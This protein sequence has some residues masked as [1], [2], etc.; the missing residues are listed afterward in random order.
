[1]SSEQLFNWKH[2]R[3]KSTFFQKTWQIYD[4]KN[5]PISAANTSHTSLSGCSLLDISLFSTVGNESHV[6][7]VKSKC[8]KFLKAWNQKSGNVLNGS[9]IY[10]NSVILQEIFS[11]RDVIASVNIEWYQLWAERCKK[12]LCLTS[13]TETE[14][15]LIYFSYREVLIYS[16]EFCKNVAGSEINW[17]KHQNGEICPVLFWDFCCSHQASALTLLDLKPTT[18]PTFI[19]PYHL[20]KFLREKP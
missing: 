15:G 14:I 7:N 3:K 20:P 18:Q 1:M 4:E 19:G 2:E 16:T 13:R 6:K 17:I 9:L 8:K 11:S 10:S 5:I 12:D